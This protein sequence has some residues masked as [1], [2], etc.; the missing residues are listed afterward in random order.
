MTR[1]LIAEDSPTV[2]ELLVEI[3]GSDPDLQVIG[4]A[5]NGVEA[6]ALTQ[7]L[8]PDVVTM[9]IQMPLMD[10]LQATQE[11]MAT[12]PTP[13]V[14]VTAS[15][16]HRA[17]EISLETMR[18]G[19]LTAVQKPQGVAAPDFEEKARQLITTVKNMAQVKVVR[20]WRPTQP[21]PAPPPRPGPRKM[22]GRIVAIATSTGGPA[23]LHQVLAQLPAR[24]PVPI[25]VVQHICQG[26]TAG[27][28][29]W[30]SSVCPFP[31]KVAEEGELLTAPKV[32]L[33]PDD[34]HLGV[35]ARNT[36]TLSS[37]PAVGGFRPSGTTLFESVAR[38]FGSSTVAV[39]MTGMGEDGVAGLKA[40]RQAGGYI[41]A[42]DE[43]SSVVFGMPGAAVAAGLPDQ[44]L[45]L[46]GIAP[47]LL[48]LVS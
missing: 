43:K 34:R 18:A 13:I 40:V 37:V 26:F 44:V 30:L 27:L 24:F 17:V 29:A 8:K 1:V 32:Y 21:T 14:I 35:T 36:I 46:D 45:P 20:R 39:I 4:Q 10:G 23:A 25:L 48:E 7:K 19:A 11:I 9:D 42:Q 47:R 28:A 41:I 31:V 22:R 6:V 15:Y 5:K 3:L 2:R 16:E 33:G 12:T 38:V